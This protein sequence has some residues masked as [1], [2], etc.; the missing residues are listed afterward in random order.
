MGRQDFMNWIV[1]QKRNRRD[2]NHC[3]P[4]FAPLQMKAASSGYFNHFATSLA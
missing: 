2:R 3:P 1:G 4:G